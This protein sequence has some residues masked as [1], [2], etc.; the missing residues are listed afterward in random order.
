MDV[1]VGDVVIYGGMQNTV[2]DE[3]NG[4]P[5]LLVVE[6]AIVAIIKE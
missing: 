1:M 5:V 4:V 6:A 3:L 2:E